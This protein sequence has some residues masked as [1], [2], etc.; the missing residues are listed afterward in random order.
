MNGDPT[1]P[2]MQAAHRW[3]K[4]SLPSTFQLH[5]THFSLP[6]LSPILLSTGSNDSQTENSVLTYSAGS[7][8]QRRACGNEAKLFPS[9]GKVVPLHLC[10]TPAAGCRMHLDRPLFLS[11]G[12]SKPTGGTTERSRYN[13]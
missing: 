2:V 9:R 7:F 1:Q 10:Q 13:H 6:Q 3:S 8:L 11:L 4:L 12:S 5:S